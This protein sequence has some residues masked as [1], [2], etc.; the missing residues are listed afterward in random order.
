MGFF[1]EDTSIDPIA[2]TQYHMG[3]DFIYKSILFTTGTK[4]SALCS[5]QK[6]WHYEI[7]MDVILLDDCL[8]PSMSSDIVNAYP[9]QLW[10]NI[11][12]FSSNFSKLSNQLKP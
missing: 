7:L 2:G 11:H 5:L 8:E 9:P 6:A 3:E 12:P 4:N 10:A 1:P